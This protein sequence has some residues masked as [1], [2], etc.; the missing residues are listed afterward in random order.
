M[1]L[2]RNFQSTLW[3][4]SPGPVKTWLP[5]RNVS[6]VWVFF[7]SSMIPSFSE[8][9]ALT[10]GAFGVLP[11]I[12]ALFGIYCFHSLA[13]SGAPCF[14][15]FPD[16]FE[17]FPLR[18]FSCFCVGTA[19]WCPSFPPILYFNT[20]PFFFFFRRVLNMSHH[21][22]PPCHDLSACQLA[23]VPTP[24][25]FPVIPPL[26]VKAKTAVLLVNQAEKLLGQLPP[27][28]S[29]CVWFVAPCFQF[30]MKTSQ[31]TDPVS[32]F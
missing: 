19:V 11:S 12:I 23:S 10:R 32:V 15:H 3:R 2:I 20:P 4:P 24:L 31:A 25:L 27:V 5:P 14:F 21:L 1:A 16:E 9:C 13:F 7:F 8:V 18:I 6:I 30:H 28:P 17:K 26:R 29:R 22:V